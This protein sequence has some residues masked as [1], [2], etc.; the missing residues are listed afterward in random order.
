MIKA[1]TDLEIFTLSYNFAMDIFRMS[2]NFTKAETYSLTDQIARSSCSIVANIAEGFGKRI[3]KNEF[4][5]HLIYAMGS[6]EGTKVWLLFAKDC[7]YVETK[8]F[9]QCCLKYDEIGAKLYRL[10]ENWKTF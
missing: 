3:Y 7:G 6:L 5:K 8:V 10:F 2:R 4:K 1:I 9:N